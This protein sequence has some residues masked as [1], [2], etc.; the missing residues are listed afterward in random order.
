MKFL[1]ATVRRQRGGVDLVG[2]LHR[3]AVEDV[4]ETVVGV[5]TDLRAAFWVVVVEDGVGATG[6][7]KREVFGTCRRDDMETRSEGM[8]LSFSFLVLGR[9]VQWEEV[10]V[11]KFFTVLRIGSPMYRLLCSRRRSG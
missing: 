6:F 2:R 8:L 3:D 11:A 7:D 5:G 9:D 1:G 10:G 4:P